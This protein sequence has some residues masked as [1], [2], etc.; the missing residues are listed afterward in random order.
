MKIAIVG[1]GA[2]GC[3]L[4]A[5]LST[6]GEHELWLLD[7]QPERAAL[8]NANPFRLLEERGERL[9]RL[10]VTAR[11]ETIGS[12]QLLLLCVK[13]HQT[14]AAYDHCALLH[15]EESLLIAL[16]NGI[17]HL[18]LL[19]ELCGS[20]PWAAGTTA[21]GATLLAPN[22]VKH[23]GHG[24][25]KLGFLYPA[26]P[27]EFALLTTAAEIF[28][29]AGIATTLSP[30]ILAALWEKLLVNAGINALTALH[31]CPNGQLPAIPEAAA[32]LEGAVREGAA[33][34]QAKGIRLPQDPVAACFAVCRATAAN[35][36]SMLQD[37]RA[38]RPT[39]IAAING[40]I[41]REGIILGIPTP[42]NLKLFRA[43]T[44]LEQGDSGKLP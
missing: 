35:L 25:T 37:I 10:K 42:I 6:R 39:E 5:K 15:G 27:R 30:N 19:A 31:D 7:R 13:S 40:A 8:L 11:A 22:Q 2:L 33:V 24:P 26:S 4:A 1:P 17:A 3:L 16:Q 36:S 43:V 12:A 44:A 38:R 32:M 28:N 18:D 23:G 21:Q 34:A 20:R 9:A 41:V 29:H 14:R